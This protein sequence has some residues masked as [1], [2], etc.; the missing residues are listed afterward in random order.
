MAGLPRE[1][2]CDALHNKCNFT[3]DNMWASIQNVTLVN[4]PGLLP[5]YPS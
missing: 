4:P 2:P 3:N 1:S 5:S